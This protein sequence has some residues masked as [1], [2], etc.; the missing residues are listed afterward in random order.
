MSA[1]TQSGHERIRIAAVQT[2]PETHFV[3]RKSLL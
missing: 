1:L 2:A 3:G